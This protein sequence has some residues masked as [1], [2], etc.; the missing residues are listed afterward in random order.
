LIHLPSTTEIAPLNVALVYNM[1]REDHT[2]NDTD[3]PPSSGPAGNEAPPAVPTPSNLHNDLYAE[4]DTEETIGAIRAALA[5]IHNV[6]LVEA[7]EQAYDRLSSLRPDIVFNIAEG[8]GGVSREAHVP[9]ILEFLRIPYTGSDP[10]T[11]ATSLDKARTKEVLAYWGV[12]TPHFGL[13]SA[14]SELTGISVGF[15]CI[16]K[17]LHEGSSKGIFN[18]SVVRNWDELWSSVRSIIETYKQPAIVEEYLEGREFTVAMLGNDENLQTLPIVEIKFDSLPDGVNPIYS[19]E[20]KWIWDQASSPLDIFEC[21]ARIPMALAQEIEMVCRKAFKALRCKDWCRID[22][23]LNSA[24]TP[25]ILEL[26][27]LPGILPNPEDNSCFPKAARAAGL[28]YNQLIQTVLHLA[29]Q[30]Q[31]ILKSHSETNRVKVA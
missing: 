12:P 22:V 15:P 17:P 14:I 29:A 31:G 8:L 9:A 3:D 27:P 21:P 1:K 16:V 19:F 5:E 13:I 2:S 6:T 25:M 10:L 20:A 11:L 7:D 24:G 28:T 26:N 18:S 23:R 30:R 4:W